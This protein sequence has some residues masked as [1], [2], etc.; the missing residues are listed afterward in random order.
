MAPLPTPA[1]PPSLVAASALSSAEQLSKLAATRLTWSPRV[2]ATVTAAQELLA[3][4]QPATRLPLQEGYR[5]RSRRATDGGVAPRGVRIEAEPRQAQAQRTV[6]KQG[7]KQSDHDIK[8]FKTLGRT[9]FACAADAQQALAGF[10][11][12]VQAN[13]LHDSTICPT[14]RYGQRGRSGPEAQPDQMV[15]HSAGALASR[16]TD[17]PARVDQQSCG[18]LATNA[19]DEGQLS[20]QAVLDGDKGP[21]QA[22]RGFRVL[23]GLAAAAVSKPT[24]A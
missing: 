11:H 1:R 9:A 21:A 4:A 12:D 22:E 17:R 2:P 18:I 24:V 8:A 7:R 3:H 10:A 14:P 13:L 19:L 6:D 5:A 16:L 15:S 20:A 23:K